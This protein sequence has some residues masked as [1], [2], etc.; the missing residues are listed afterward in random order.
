[1]RWVEYVAH[2]GEGCRQSYCR[3]IGRKKPLGKP[4]HTW[5][6]NIKM[7]LTAPEWEHMD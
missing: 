7:D 1:M 4:G 3:K 2:L 6:D 5:K